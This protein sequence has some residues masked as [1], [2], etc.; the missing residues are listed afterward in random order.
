MADRTH[1]ELSD[2]DIARVADTY[3]A[4]R[5]GK[6]YEDVAGFCKV[7]TLDNIRGH[8]YVLTPGRYVGVPEQEDD[9]EPFEEKMTRL[10]AQLAE[11]MAEG[12]RLDEQIRK[13]LND[14]GFPLP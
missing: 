3:H 10:T 5:E 14:L 1:K 8:N 9:G 12:A 7:A 11:Q 6:G 13:N 4:W 2:A